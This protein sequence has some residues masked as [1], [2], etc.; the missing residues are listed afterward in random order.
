M[1]KVYT[2]NQR[3]EAL[4]RMKKIGL[5]EDVIE[6]FTLH[7]NVQ[8]S[9][10][11]KF[12]GLNAAARKALAEL[13]END[14]GALPYHIVFTSTAFGRMY[15][16]LYVSSYPEEWDDDFE[17][18]KDGACLCAYVM[19]QD[20]PECSEFGDIEIIQQNGTMCRVS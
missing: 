16:V 6:D 3:S 1:A 18:T 10:D 8:V 12:I 7:S 15:A 19:N 5:R 2:V 4:K 14:A 11:H 17:A 9:V 20:A 13:A